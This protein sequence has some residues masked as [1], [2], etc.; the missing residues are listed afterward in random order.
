MSFLRRMLI[1]AVAVLMFLTACGDD[2]EREG[3]GESGAQLAEV[4]LRLDWLW[5]S[6]HA[7][8]FVAQEKG[9]FE[10]A[11]LNVTIREG[12]GSSVSAKLVGNR[13][14]DFGIVAAGTVMASVG[15]GVPIKT[16]ATLLQLNPT[17][18]I[19]QQDT[20]VDDAQ[21]LHG[22]KLGV[23]IDSVTYNEWEAVTE[24]NNVDRDQINEIGVG[25]NI[26]QALLADRVDAAIGWSFNQFLETKLKGGNVDFVSFDDL[27]LEIPS[28]TLVANSEMIASDPETVD[29]FV[30][31]VLKGWE[32]T[33]DNPD[34]A[35]DIFLNAHPEVD[36][37][38]NTEKLPLVLELVRAPD[39][40]TIGFSNQDAWEELK[41]FYE[42][43]G[44]LEED[45][46]L[47][48][49]FTNEFVEN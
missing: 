8:Y 18:I 36:Q 6:E 20:P 21:D 10:E 35:L 46:S 3:G 15:Q 4:S 34:E 7:P 30:D 12:E 39:T 1:S 47:D 23:I 9:F 40:E 16:A 38:Y 41:N 26:V 22:K 37:E 31:A 17:G 25:E 42:D 13:N 44:L 32:F 5:G 11:G 29:A 14:D 43:S 28:S 24:I 2:E 49:V 19:Y 33:L 27:G 45:V 48:E